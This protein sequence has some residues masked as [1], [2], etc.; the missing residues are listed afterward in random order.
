MVFLR[1]VF[2]GR[3]GPRFRGSRI[4]FSEGCSSSI[5][6]S[7]SDSGPVLIRKYSFTVVDLKSVGPLDNYTLYVSPSSASR[8][9]SPVYLLL[10]PMLPLR[11]TSTSELR[12]RSYT[13]VVSVPFR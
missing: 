4:V 13:G 1:S 3:L 10:W 11:Q 8:V 2:L 12:G 9:Y 5:S 7:G 6:L